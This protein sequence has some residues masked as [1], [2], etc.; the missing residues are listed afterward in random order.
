MEITAFLMKMND[1]VMELMIRYWMCVKSNVTA[2]KVLF[3]I[4]LMISMEVL[5]TFPFEFPQKV[6]HLFP[7]NPQTKH[8]ARLQQVSVLI[9]LKM[10]QTLPTELL[11]R[12]G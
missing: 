9:N 3:F 4:I 5:T 7:Q 2:W 10:G 1:F 6:P 11:P 12:I 8:K